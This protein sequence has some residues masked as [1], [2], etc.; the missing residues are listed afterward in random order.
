MFVTWTIKS[1]GHS[2][3]FY[4]SIVWIASFRCLSS[5]VLPLGKVTEKVQSNTGLCEA[6]NNPMDGLQTCGR[7]RCFKL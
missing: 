3:Q 7:A 5:Y 4:L 6:Q 1:R 2:K